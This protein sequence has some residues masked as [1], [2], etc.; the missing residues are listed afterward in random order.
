VYVF[1]GPDFTSSVALTPLPAIK[2]SDG[3]SQ[4]G[5]TDGDNIADL[6]LSGLE[7]HLQRSSFYGGANF[8][9]SI[10]ANTPNF[11]FTSSASGFGKALAVIGDI[12]GAGGGEIAIGAPN[13]VV[14]LNTVTSRDVGSVYIVNVNGTT[15][16]NIDTATPGAAGPLLVRLDGETLFS[17]FGSSITALGDTDAGGKPDFAVGAP[18]ERELEHLSGTVY[19]FKGG[20][21]RRRRPLGE[22]VR[23][24]GHGKG[25]GLWNS[26]CR[27]ITD[28][29]G[30][31]HECDPYRGAAFGR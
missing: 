17:R 28:R 1:F 23:V 18:A 6:A 15:P 13:A 26:A 4:Q 11:V 22:H 20:G 5:D 25:P 24:R 10:N 3:Q 29:T 16:V 7:Q 14:S 21:H 8:I 12:N 30:W 9:A 2:G 19:V 27:R 31:R